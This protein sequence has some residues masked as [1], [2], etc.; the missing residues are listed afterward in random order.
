MSAKCLA[1]CKF[2]TFER[3]DEVEDGRKH[4][5]YRRGDKTGVSNDETEPLY[6]AHDPV[7][8]SAHIIRGE[9][10]HE[11]IES[12]RRRTYS[13]Q[14][15]DFEEDEDEAGYPK[16]PLAWLRAG[17]GYQRHLQAYYAEDNDQTDVE[18]VCDS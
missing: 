15:R 12:R 9:A 4:Q 13:K 6:Q 1:P 14:Q 18:E 10:A 3:S 16:A 2:L 7:H 5:K 17:A 8:G 11:L